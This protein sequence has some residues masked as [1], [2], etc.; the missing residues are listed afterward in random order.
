VVCPR[1]SVVVRRFPL[2]SLVL[3]T[4]PRVVHEYDIGRLQ[5]RR[6]LWMVL[7]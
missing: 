5:R 1:A 6:S 3:V 2:A 7:A 4:F